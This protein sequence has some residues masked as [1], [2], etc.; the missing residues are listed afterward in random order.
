MVYR[1]SVL[2]LVATTCTSGACTTTLY[3][4]IEKKKTLENLKSF[5]AINPQAST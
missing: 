3:L 5:S 2:L 1:H 4:A